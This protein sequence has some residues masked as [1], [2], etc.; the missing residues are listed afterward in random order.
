MLAIFPSPAGM[1]VTKLINLKTKIIN[2][3]PARESL[4]SDIPG[5]DGKIANL[6]GK[7]STS[8]AWRKTGA[9]TRI[10]SLKIVTNEKYGVG[11]V[12]NVMYWRR[13]VLMDVVCLLIFSPSCIKPISVS[14]YSSQII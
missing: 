6:E 11:K 5:G 9:V 10:I 7:C 4:V 13:T 2:L 3:F 1:L 8:R 12:A 14:A